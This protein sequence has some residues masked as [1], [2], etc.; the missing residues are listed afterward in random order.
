MRRVKRVVVLSAGAVLVVGFAVAQLRYDFTVLTSQNG[1]QF[2]VSVLGNW[3]IRAQDGS[4]FVTLN[5]T[6]VSANMALNALELIT[7]QGTTTR[8]R[9][10]AT[11]SLEL[12]PPLPPAPDPALRFRLETINIDTSQLGTGTQR[13]FTRPVAAGNNPFVRTTSLSARARAV[14]RDGNGNRTSQQGTVEIIATEYRFPANDPNARPD[15]VVIRYYE[16]TSFEAATYRF[17]Y[18]ARLTA[19]ELFMH[20]RWVR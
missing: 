18:T 8:A 12:L 4:A 19:G 6:N 17:E 11:F 13:L 2:V 7:A 20:T 9:R 10:A 16:G 14:R 5:G 3:E 15:E 1:N